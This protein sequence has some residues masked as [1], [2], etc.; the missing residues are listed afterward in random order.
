MRYAHI[1]A[2]VLSMPWAL[3]PEKLSELS[4]ILAMRALG[5][6]FTEEE[7][8]ARISA[9]QERAAARGQGAQVGAVAVMPILGMLLPRAE[10]MSQTS[11]AVSVQALRAR[12]QQLD[13]DPAVGAIVLDFDSVGG[14]V[15]G[16]AEFADAVHA[17]TKPV[18]AISNPTM[19]SAAYFIGSQAKALLVSPSSLTG[20]IGVYAA[21]EDI[22]KALEM[23][24]K[25]V[26]LVSA[27]AKK[28]LTTKLG[29][30]TEEGRAEL[31]AR[32]DGFYEQFVRAVARGRGVSQKAVREG[33]G[34]GGVVLAEDA[35]KFGMADAVGTLEDAIALAARKAK[36][37]GVHAEADEPPTAAA[38]DAHAP[39]ASGHDL[40]VLRLRAR[41]AALA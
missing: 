23:E 4:S 12:F 26:T 28:V 29:P 37:A 36:S 20:S 3:L 14:S 40:D 33:F 2:E 13:A 5:H 41:H 7:I 19:A 18:I 10:A 24:G 31:Q 22:S 8:E 38:G 39:V 15:G 11:G 21:H 17:A 27:G 34:Q 1:L 25:T 16:V 35:V 30:L 9:G 32:V 6:R